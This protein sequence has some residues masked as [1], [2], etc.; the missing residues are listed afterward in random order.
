M[1]VINARLYSAWNPSIMDTLGK[2]VSLFRGVTTEV[3]SNSGVH[4]R[5]R[6]LSAVE[7]ILPPPPPPPKKKNLPSRFQQG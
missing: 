6:V 2:V 3:S 7:K 5:G 1:M 4:N